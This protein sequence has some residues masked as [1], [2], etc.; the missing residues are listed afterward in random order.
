[1]FRELPQ[2]RLVRRTLPA[3]RSMSAILKT[4]PTWFARGQ[5]R[6]FLDGRF[7]YYYFTLGRGRPKRC[8]PEQIYFTHV[9]EIIGHFDIHEI[10]QNVGQLPKL[11]TLDGKASA[12]QI[13]GD[14]WVAVCQPPFHWLEEKIYHEGF[15]G[16][17]YF[18]LDSYRGTIGAKIRI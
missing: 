4:L 14:A 17:R 6:E 15:R 1:L 2:S 18:D 16:W 8:D 13:K 5:I 7:C 3:H 10:V 11:T 9:G 12:W